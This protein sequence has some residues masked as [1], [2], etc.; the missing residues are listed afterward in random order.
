MKPTES[1]LTVYSDQHLLSEA[2]IWPAVQLCG[3]SLKHAAEP[4]AKTTLHAR[5]RWTC[6][7]GSA[8][9]EQT[10]PMIDGRTM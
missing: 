10:K 8:T 5:R 1:S 9:S 2:M 7:R 4:S 3:F 6:Q